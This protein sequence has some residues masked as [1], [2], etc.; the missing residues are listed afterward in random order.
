MQFTKRAC[1][2]VVCSHHFEMVAKLD[3]LFHRIEVNHKKANAGRSPRVSVAMRAPAPAAAA[4]GTPKHR[5][6]PSVMVVDSKQ[7]H[8]AWKDNKGDDSE[9]S[10]VENAAPSAGGGAGAGAAH[11]RRTP[12]RAVSTV[13]TDSEVRAWSAPSREDTRQLLYVVLH[14]ADISNPAKPWRV[15]KLWYVCPAGCAWLFLASFWFCC[16]FV[17]FCVCVVVVLLFVCRCTESESV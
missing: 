10:D 6:N 12:T 17:C 14:A 15:A 7:I 1:L 13:E 4:G 8:L 3:Q 16:L 11:H 2:C 5:A 9:G